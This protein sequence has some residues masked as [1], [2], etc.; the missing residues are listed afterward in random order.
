MEKL[1]AGFVSFGSKDFPREP[2]NRRS[3]EAR[4]GVESK[5]I[6]L[7][8][9]GPVSTLKGAYRSVEDLKKGEF[10]FLI[11]CVASWV[12]SPLVM[13]VA[14][15]FSHK[16][17]LLWGMGGYTRNG[18]L[19]APAAQAG[20]TGLREPL[21]AAGFKFKYIYDWPDSPMNLD[22]VLSFAKVAR[23]V[24]KLAHARV[25]MMG[26]GDMGLYVT[27]FDGL[28]LRAKIGPE[29]EVFDMLEITQKM[30]KVSREDIVSVVT[31]VQKNWK[32]QS[33][34]A[35]ETLEKMARIYLAFKE[36]IKEGGYEAISIKCVEG[37]KK[38]MNFPPCMILSLLT[39]EVTGICEDDALS[40]V[41]QL[42]IKYLTEQPAPYV[43][44]YEFMK[45]R[46]LAG[47]CGFVPSG[48]VEGP[49]C[50][51]GY[52]GWGGLSAGVMNVS[53]MKT[54]R[55]TISKLFSRGDQYKMHI[56]TGEGLA[57][58]KWEELGW[59]PPAPRFPSLEIVPDVSMEQF[60]QKV[61]S[62]HY[63]VAYGDQREKLEDL[64]RILEIEIVT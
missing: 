12:E 35:D 32:F 44:I 33:E 55:I 26:Y 56:V 57:P 30:E 52:G 49:V 42:M 54:G 38:Y 36:K 50:V 62:Q 10:D 21:A 20:T 43:E 9:T 18:S 60:A 61:V 3:E 58:R 63:L 22:K 37:M 23:A 39:D 16:P 4:K 19:V 24:R 51:T 41:N 5:G 27:M 47:V 6:E 28:S 13:A 7:I 45:D 40:A 31:R 25:G 1:K 64:G 2:I 15:E 17:M 53:K 48:V 34:V 46:I 14:R 8:A 29:V 11:L 59:N